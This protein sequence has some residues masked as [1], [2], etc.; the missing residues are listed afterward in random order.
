MHIDIADALAEKFF[1]LYEFQN[2]CIQGDDR[3][4]QVMKFCQDFIPR[5]EIAQC[6]FTDHEWMNKQAVILQQS[7]N[8]GVSHA[9]VI[10]PDRGVG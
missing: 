8:R 9:K 6:N 1:P 3:A 2:V 5:F 7:G 4:W 10:Y